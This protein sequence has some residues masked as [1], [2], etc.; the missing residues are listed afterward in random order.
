MRREL[1]ENRSIYVAPL[2]AAGLMI[3]A[4]LII[5]IEASIHVQVPVAIPAGSKGPLRYG[6]PTSS[7]L[8]RFMPQV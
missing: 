6:P 7:W 3:I 1:W 8:H 2:V 4:L 5:A